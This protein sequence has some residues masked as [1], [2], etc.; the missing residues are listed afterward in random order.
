MSSRTSVLSF[1]VWP[2][3][4]QEASDDSVCL[5]YSG[6]DGNRCSCHIMSIVYPDDSRYVCHWGYEEFL[7]TPNPFT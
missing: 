2:V 5:I 3:E 6:N 7:V 4:E 1:S